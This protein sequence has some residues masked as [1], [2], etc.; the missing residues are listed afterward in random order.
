MCANKVFIMFS[1][2]VRK[3]MFRTAFTLLASGV[4]IFGGSLFSACADDA[5]RHYGLL[6]DIYSDYFKIGAATSS[7]MLNHEKDLLA[8]FNSITSTYEMKWGVIEPQS[9]KYNYGGADRLLQWASEQNISVRGHCLVWYRNVPDWVAETA[10]NKET[11][12]ALIDSHIRKTMTH[13][14]GENIYCWDVVNE[15]LH[16]NITKEQL[17]SG[18]IYRNAKDDERHFARDGVF[19][20]YA[21]CGSDYIARALKTADQVCDENGYT[22]MQ[23]FY[24]DYLLNQPLKRDACIQMVKELRA[25]GVRIDGI[26]MQAHYSLS[27]Y[28]SDKR[29]WIKDFEAAV[30]AYTELGLD[31]NITELDIDTGEKKLS[32]KTEKLQAEMYGKIFDICRKY[33]KPWKNGA[34][35]I[36]G[37]TTWGVKDSDGNCK[38]LFDSDGNPKAAI[39]EITYF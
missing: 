14:G 35:C 15:A 25:E 19:D 6:C 30:R 12:L 16:D 32:E 36:T 31:V 17:E 34:G 8:N 3:K 9:S 23:L 13:F 39:D 38:Y 21:A 18:N 4:L 24:N 20:W 22:G 27:S 28:T 37:V 1:V 5:Q 10:V 7:D 11:A 29:G 2:T 26:G 33:S